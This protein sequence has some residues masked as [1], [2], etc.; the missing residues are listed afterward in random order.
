MGGADYVVATDVAQAVAL[1][2]AGSRVLAGGTDHYPVLVGRP[3]VGPVVDITRIA[4][5]RGIAREGDRFRFGA[6]TTWADVARADLPRGFDALRAAARE[7]GAVQVQNAGTIAGNLVTASPAGDGVPSFLALDASVEVTGPKGARELPLS[8]FI[9]G[10]RA[11]ALAPDEIVTAVCV[12]A[13]VADAGSSFQKLG[14]RRY[15]V[16]SIVMVAAQIESAGGK[17][18]AARVAV[19]SCSPVAQRLPAF[20]ADLVGRGVGDDLAALVEERHLAPL[21]PID[22]VRATAAY[23]MRAA[24]TLVGRAICEAAE[25]SR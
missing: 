19:G 17:V 5:L 16:I 11:T 9:T 3:P 6:L 24:R 2:A 13:S 1:K 22:D 4:S 21:S 14:L 7:V 10:Y 23:R 18:T 12:P 15:L 8:S 25:R 20:E